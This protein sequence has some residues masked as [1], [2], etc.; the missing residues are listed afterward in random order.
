MIKPATP[1]DTSAA[2]QAL[3][4]ELIEVATDR[5]Q[6]GLAPP[7]EFYQVSSRARVDWSLFPSWAVP[8]DPDVFDGCCHEG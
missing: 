8:I 4:R 1:S 3:D 5:V 2:R 7:A 6:C